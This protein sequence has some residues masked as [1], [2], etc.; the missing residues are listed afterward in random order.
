[1]KWIGHTQGSLQSK[2]SPT[3]D[4]RGANSSQRPQRDVGRRLL[5]ISTHIEP[6]HHTCISQKQV[7]LRV[8]LSYSIYNTYCTM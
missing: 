3:S 1:M 5:E 2:F 4:L 7:Q 6:S 8:N